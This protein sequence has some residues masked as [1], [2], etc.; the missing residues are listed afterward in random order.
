MPEKVLLLPF[1]WIKK[2]LS[3]INKN[4]KQIH[5]LIRTA[6]FD[7]SPFNRNY[8]YI[9]LSKKKG[10]F[11]GVM[12]I[13]LFIFIKCTYIHTCVAYNIEVGLILKAVAIFCYFFSSLYV[14]TCIRIQNMQK[15]QRISFYGP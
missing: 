2:S 7:P 5:T 3:H 9:F 6:L 1:F 10:I 8:Y 11:L 12:S 14:R 13:H 15:K 4:I